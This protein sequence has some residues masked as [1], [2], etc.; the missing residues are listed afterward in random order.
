MNE[1]IRIGPVL[2]SERPLTGQKTSDQQQTATEFLMTFCRLPGARIRRMLPPEQS[3]GDS[4][5]MSVPVH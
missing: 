2:V 1:S 5:A 4:R 3:A